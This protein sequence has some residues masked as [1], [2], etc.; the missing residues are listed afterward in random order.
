MSCGLTHFFTVTKKAQT[1]NA[2]LEQNVANKAVASLDVNK[3][4]DI[5]L[6]RKQFVFLL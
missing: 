6:Q 4:N 3:K 2:S 1:K 5:R